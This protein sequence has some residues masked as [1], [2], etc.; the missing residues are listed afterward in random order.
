MSELSTDIVFD[1]MYNLFRCL[2][3][4]KLSAGR[5]GGEIARNSAFMHI[6]STCG[7]QQDLFCFSG[8][9]CNFLSEVMASPCET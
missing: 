6:H 5:K 7:E 2:E 1:S 8:K 3:G 9:L 4:D